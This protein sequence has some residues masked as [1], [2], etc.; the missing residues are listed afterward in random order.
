MGGYRNELLTT[1]QAAALLGVGTTSVKRW[2]DAGIIEC[3]RT[4]GRH[5]RIPRQAIE[6]MLDREPTGDG[7]PSPVPD[8]EGWL[9]LLIG[10]GTADEIHA[11][12]WADHTKLG[13]WWRVAELLA[14]L[15]AELGR[16]WQ[17]GEISILQE[18]LA[19]ER[20][21]RA[22]AR[23]GERLRA[24]DDAPTALLTLAEGEEHA[25]GL[26]LAELCLREA[27]WRTQWAGRRTPIDS[28]CAHVL[29]GAAQLVAV[30]ASA[31]SSDRALL[32][33]HAARLGRACH[34]AGAQ[35]LL[36]GEAPWPDP[37]PFGLRVRS[38]SDLA[39]IPIAS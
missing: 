24:P 10:R 34:D 14:G 11:R 19:S 8:I 36:G 2:A 31:S 9:T 35:L 17:R 5:R 39:V 18:H 7:Q 29:S 16:R 32:A 27:G 33:E 38:F 4:P 22:L 12:L 25:L 13:T 1:R 3:V 23:C 20:L 26:A 21:Q 37:P 6:A 30:S 15:L 28:V